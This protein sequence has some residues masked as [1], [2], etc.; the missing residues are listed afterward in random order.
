MFHAEKGQFNCV[1]F[2][3]YTLAFRQKWTENHLYFSD[4]LLFSPQCFLLHY[5][6]DEAITASQELLD[7]V[8]TGLLDGPLHIWIPHLQFRL[9]LFYNIK[10]KV[11]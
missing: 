1:D 10:K 3:F 8:S 11:Q 9:R 7:S 5:H 6:Q 2:S 4:V